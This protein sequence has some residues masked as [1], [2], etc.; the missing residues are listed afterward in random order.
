V[1]ALTERC[2]SDVIAS[3]AVLGE[4]RGDVLIAQ[5]RIFRCTA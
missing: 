1:V 2:P 5:V 3:A 4:P